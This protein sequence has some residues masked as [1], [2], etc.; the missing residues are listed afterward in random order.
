MVANTM[1]CHPNIR[2]VNYLSK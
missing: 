2:H 1:S